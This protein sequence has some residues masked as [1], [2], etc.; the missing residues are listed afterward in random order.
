VDIAFTN[1]SLRHLCESDSAARKYFGADVAVRLRARLADIDAAVNGAELG[2]GRPRQVESSL[3]ALDL[4]EGYAMLLEAAEPKP[5][6]EKGGV[7]WRKVI[8]VK[9]LKIAKHD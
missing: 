1:K 9:V 5:H 3:L 6:I 7:D 4:S 8:R 2:A